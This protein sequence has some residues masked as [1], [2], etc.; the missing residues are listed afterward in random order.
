[1]RKRRSEN[2][3]G[4]TR[5]DQRPHR[6]QRE[7][8]SIKPLSLKRGNSGIQI[9]SGINN[10]S[11]QP[12]SF[13]LCS[14]IHLSV[15]KFSS[16]QASSQGSPASHTTG[17]FW[18]WTSWEIGTFSGKNKGCERGNSL[19]VKLEFHRSGFLSFF[20]THPLPGL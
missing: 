8:Y 12:N 15:A 6:F 4:R 17:L 7:C 9:L 19:G 5:P 20:V 1:M 2:D 11:F 13:F 3:S 18:F 16:S 10:S 14:G